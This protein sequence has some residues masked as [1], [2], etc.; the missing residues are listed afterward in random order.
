MAYFKSKRGCFSNGHKS[1]TSKTSNHQQSFSEVTEFHHGSAPTAADSSSDQYHNI[2]VPKKSDLRMACSIKSGLSGS[3]NTGEQFQLSQCAAPSLFMRPP[4]IRNLFLCMTIS[5]A[6][7]PQL[8]SNPLLSLL[9]STLLFLGS[10]E[11]V[12][13]EGTGH[14]VSVPELC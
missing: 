11:V 7:C 5:S 13:A 4:D 14:V 6:L 3:Y 8:A 2:R 1:L 10:V 9:L 12:S